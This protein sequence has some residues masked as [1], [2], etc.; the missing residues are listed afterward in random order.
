MESKRCCFILPLFGQ[1]LGYLIFKY[2]TKTL[3]SFCIQLLVALSKILSLS[4]VPRKWRK[5]IELQNRVGP[6]RRRS[7]GACISIIFNT[8][9]GIP[10]PG[11]PC[12]W[13]IVTVY[14]NTYVNHLAS[15]A[16]STKTCRAGETLIHRTFWRLDIW[17]FDTRNGFS[18]N[19]RIE[20]FENWDAHRLSPPLFSSF[21]SSSLFRYSFAFF[22]R[23]HRPRAWQ[24]TV[25]S[26][27]TTY[28]DNQPNVH[29][30]SAFSKF[31]IR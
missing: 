3:A 10:A 7:G 21:L 12:V 15:H 11:I 14:F 25:L 22:V 4:H 28:V 17:H 26:H 19:G 27:Y 1:G 6:G 5:R 9:S 18:G 24:L 16:Q 8:S 2:K 29:H 23:R 13:S 31:R 30:G 20:V